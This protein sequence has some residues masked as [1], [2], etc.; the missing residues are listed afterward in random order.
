MRRLQKWTLPPLAAYLG[1]GLIT[2]LIKTCKVEVVG[3]EHLHDS[4][5]KGKTIV[6]LWHNRLALITNI[7]W[8]AARQYYYAAVI[9]QSRDGDLLA[10]IANFYKHGKAIR[11]PHNARHKAV[12]AMVDHLNDG[13]IILITPDGPRGPR[14]RVKKGIA[15]TAKATGASIVPFTWSANRFFQLKT[16]DKTIIP[17]PFS[18]IRVHF[19]PAES[20]DETLEL[21][22]ITDKLQEKMQ[23][24]DQKACSAITEE[25]QLWPQ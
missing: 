5:E 20:I 24:L 3:V 6:M 25:Q 13:V 7:L 8:K 2:L 23:L 11:V 19:G 16:W 12:K 9:S 10:A 4:A 21:S 1:Q 15:Y 18:T 17:K 14:Y 22:L